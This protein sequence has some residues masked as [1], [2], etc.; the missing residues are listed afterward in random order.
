MEYPS[1]ISPKCFSVLVCINSLK[2]AYFYRPSEYCE[3]LGEEG[4]ITITPSKVSKG[5]IRA[6]V[7]E[8]GKK[9]LT[10]YTPRDLA[11]VSLEHGAVPSA[12]RYI[13]TI[14]NMGQLPDFLVHEDVI[15]RRAARYR[16]QELR[17]GKGVSGPIRSATLFRGY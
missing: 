8:K 17:Q 16:A 6:V 13:H 7:A 5:S 14:T 15:I 9:L 10:G 4:F 2:E 1:E 12:V 3:H 11:E